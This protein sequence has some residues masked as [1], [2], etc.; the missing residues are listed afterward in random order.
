MT[1]LTPHPCSRNVQEPR[2]KWLK[3]SESYKRLQKRKPEKLRYTNG[4]S[5]SPEIAKSIAEHSRTAC[6]GF[7]SFCPCQKSRKPCVFN[8]CGIL[9]FK[10]CKKCAFNFCKPLVD[11]PQKTNDDH[12]FYGVIV[13]CFFIFA[14]LSRVFTRY[15][16]HAYR[17]TKKCQLCKRR[18]NSAASTAVIT[19]STLR[20]VLPSPAVRHVKNDPAKNSMDRPA[21][22]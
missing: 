19:N 7:E 3:T 6:R 20:F 14:S 21:N 2:Q 5:Q 17:I 4:Y 16:T 18:T 9:F 8:A 12:T 10:M 11:T 13:I 15:N 22:T 1:G